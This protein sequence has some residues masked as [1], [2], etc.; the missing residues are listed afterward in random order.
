MSKKKK[1]IK[2]KLKERERR[3]VSCDRK[4]KKSN[5]LPNRINPKQYYIKNTMIHQPIVKLQKRI[6]IYIERERERERVITFFGREIENK[7]RKRS[8]K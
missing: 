6:Y 2:Q 1:K 5:T 4:L 7:I 8:I 3:L